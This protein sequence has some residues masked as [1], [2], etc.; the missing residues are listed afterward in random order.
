MSCIDKQEHETS[1]AGHAVCKA[2]MVSVLI[3]T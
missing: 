1:D 2:V 3:R